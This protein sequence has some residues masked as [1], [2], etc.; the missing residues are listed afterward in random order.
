MKKHDLLAPL[1]EVVGSKYMHLLL[2]S[3]VVYSISL[4]MIAGASL[5]AIG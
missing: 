4:V 5:V 3:L 2:G 1:G